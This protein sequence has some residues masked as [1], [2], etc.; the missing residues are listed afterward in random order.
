[1]SDYGPLL[2]FLQQGSCRVALLRGGMHVFGLFVLPCIPFNEGLVG[3]L[4]IC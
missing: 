3:Q 1:M 2:P 4:K